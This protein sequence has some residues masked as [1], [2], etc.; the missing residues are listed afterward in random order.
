M[1][2][3]TGIPIGSFILVAGGIVLRI[4]PTKSNKE[5]E[6]LKEN[7]I[8]EDRFVEFKDGLNGRLDTIEKG[9]SSIRELLMKEK[10]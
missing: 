6:K 9:V 7:I 3:G 5:L 2:I 4:M 8:Y 1:D 10:Q